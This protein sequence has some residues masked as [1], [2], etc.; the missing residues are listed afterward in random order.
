MNQKAGAFLLE[1]VTLYWK[2]D[3]SVPSTIVLNRL[4]VI[5]FS[6]LASA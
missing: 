5:N 2:L 3:K 1:R 6:E 4:W